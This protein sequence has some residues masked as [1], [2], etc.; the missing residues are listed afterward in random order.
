MAAA[1]RTSASPSFKTRRKPS[2]ICSEKLEEDADDDTEEEEEELEE[3]E[4][5]D[6]DSTLSP[7]ASHICS[8][9]QANKEF[10]T[11]PEKNENKT[12]Q[13]KINNDADLRELIGSDVTNSPRL[14][15]TQACERRDNSLV[16]LM[17][18]VNLGKRDDSIDSEQTNRVLVITTQRSYCCGKLVFDTIPVAVLQQFLKT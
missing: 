15:C 8:S 10:E 16:G 1:V 5:E 3:E 17:G 9:E 2:S 7:M 13:N 6:L 11:T 14:V 18:V 12:K 4:E